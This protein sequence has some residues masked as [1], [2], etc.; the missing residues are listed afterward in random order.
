MTRGCRS[1]RGWNVQRIHLL[2]CRG[3][4]A[5]FTTGVF[6][7]LTFSIIAWKVSSS[8]K[9]VL[10]WWIKSTRLWNVTGYINHTPLQVPCTEDDSSQGQGIKFHTPWT[11]VVDT[12]K[13]SVL[14]YSS[15][16]CYWVN[17]LQVV[18]AWFFPTLKSILGIETAGAA[19][20][21]STG[22]RHHCHPQNLGTE[23]D[24]VLCSI[25]LY[26]LSSD[27]GDLALLSLTD[28]R[29]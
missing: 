18:F 16:Q 22:S 14:L 12:L 1:Q 19:C 13:Y 26:L 10:S 24:V 28:P 5:S 23:Y 4:P 11:L 25:S 20:V 8:E 21:E 15:V 27:L 3:T 7:Y 2:Y 6:L 9:V 17:F 29:S